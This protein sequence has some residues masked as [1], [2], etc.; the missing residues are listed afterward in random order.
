[1]ETY[2][3]IT[4]KSWD[5]FYKICHFY[6]VKKDQ[7]L[8][9]IG[10]VPENIYFVSKGLL[11]V[12]CLSGKESDKEVNKNFFDEG[13]FPASIVALLK[14][15]DSQFC[16]QAIETSKLI[17]INHTNYRE[18]LKKHNDLMW[19]HIYYLEKNWIMKK[20]PQEIS[21]L[22]LTAKERYQN[23]QKTYPDLINRVP[24]YHLASSLGITPTQL[25]RIRKEN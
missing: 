13:T 16:I 12:Y 15:E 4:Q 7:V 6:E 11:R 2:H 25:S 5:E 19:F 3:P 14:Q 10:E 17:K 8:V 1:M 22:S 9:K 18:L 21:Y 20:E 23:F 24:L